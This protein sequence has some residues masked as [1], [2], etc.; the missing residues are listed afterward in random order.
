VALPLFCYPR[1][2]LGIATGGGRPINPRSSTTAPATES[3]RTMELIASTT[4]D[5]NDVRA[6]NPEEVII[7]SVP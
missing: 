7:A 4:G 5:D 6:S 1:F 3:N 2:E